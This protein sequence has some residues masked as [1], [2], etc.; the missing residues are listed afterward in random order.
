MRCRCRQ[1]SS[2]REGRRSRG[3]EGAG[4]E[5]GRSDGEYGRVQP[6]RQEEGRFDAASESSIPARVD[7]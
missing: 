6:G 3:G 1:R 5:E 7:S 4:E 2:R